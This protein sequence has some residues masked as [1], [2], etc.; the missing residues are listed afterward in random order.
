MILS[1]FFAEQLFAVDMHVFQLSI[2][3]I[4]L[5]LLT[6]LITS[7]YLLKPDSVKIFPDGKSRKIVLFYF[8]W[9]F[10][11]I[12]SLA[13][14]YDYKPWF[15]TVYAIASGVLVIIYLTMFLKNKKDFI[16]AFNIVQIMLIMH[17]IIGWY[18]IFTGDYRF[19]DS[20]KLDYYMMVDVAGRNPVSMLGNTN[21]FALLISMGAFISFICF[22]NSNNMLWK[23]ISLGT[24]VSSIVLLIRTDSRAN[25]L[26]FIIAMGVFVLL[27][28][29][30]A[31]NIKNFVLIGVCLSILALYPTFLGS[32]YDIL[33]QKLQ[34][35]FVASTGSSMEIRINL[36][37]NGFLF[38]AQTLGFGTG[39]GNI[40][41]WMAHKGI[42][43]TRNI[44]NIHNWWMELLVGYGIIVFAGYLWMYI[45]IARDFYTACSQIKDKFI[46]S[47]S[48][49]LLCCMIE[50]VLGSISSSS[51]IQTQ[52]LWIFWGLVIAMYYYIDIVTRQRSEDKLSNR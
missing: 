31:K 16:A 3:K 15:R 4:T 20:E 29:F 36:M 33:S 19:L 25:I 12:I 14:V 23:L 1:S 22:K 11:A 46:Q 37:K 8:F 38:L 41:Y 42:F 18:E 6:F 21:D 13:W 26:G 27:Y 32:I 28:F 9:L 51:N 7:I 49:G 50:F 45:K 30:K 52:W 48:L 10:W 47:V 43:Y 39:A 34:F 44:I 5:L 17:N 24:I 40:E 2:Y 35:G